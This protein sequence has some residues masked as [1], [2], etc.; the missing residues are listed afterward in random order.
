MRRPYVKGIHRLQTPNGELGVEHAGLELIELTK[1]IGL[2]SPV[3]FDPE[4]NA[5]AGVYSDELALYRARRG[6]RQVLEANFVLQL[7]HDFN[8]DVV[9]DPE[10]GRYLMR[11]EF[12]SA[13]AKSAFWRITHHQA[14]ET[15]CIIETA[16]IPIADSLFEN[17]I[18]APDMQPLEAEAP[19]IPGWREVQRASP[20][21]RFL[22]HLR[23]SLRGWWKR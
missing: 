18:A 19:F 20:L 14:P 6:W 17:L 1:R 13:C 11:C 22:G 16:H 8:I 21:E 2:D 3:R 7:G 5:L 10:A 12:V 23:R 9:A 4:T 15:Q